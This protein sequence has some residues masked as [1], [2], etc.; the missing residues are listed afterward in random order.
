MELTIKPRS[1]RFDGADARWREQVGAFY[2]DLRA[3]VE[4]THIARTPIPGEKGPA[5]DIILALGSSGALS[6]AVAVFKAWL[7]RDRTR[8]L[9]IAW[10]EG[11]KERCLSVRAQDLDEETFE[12]IARAAATDFNGPG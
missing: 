4:E 10:R 9:E 3:E 12:E 5:T 6:A 11:H 1:E 8:S 2:R 7:A